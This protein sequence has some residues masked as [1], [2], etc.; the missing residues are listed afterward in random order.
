MKMNRLMAT[1][2]NMDESVG[3]K[4]TDTKEYNV[5]FHIVNSKPGK[6]NLW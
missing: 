4:K 2:N 3:W 1:C 5:W 6:I